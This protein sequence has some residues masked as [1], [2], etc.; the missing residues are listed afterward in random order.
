[1]FQS[2]SPAGEQLLL[3]T[4]QDKTANDYSPD[5]R[6]IL[7][8]SNDQKTG[9]DLWVLPLEGKREPYVFLRTSS[10]ERRAAFS[11]DGRWVT[12]LSNESGPYA[13]YVRP[14]FEPNSSSPTR[15]SAGA[16]SSYWQISTQG[17][18]QPR[19]SPDGKEVY[20]ISPEGKLMAVPIKVT[21]GTLEAGA[22]VALFAPKI[23]GVDSVDAGLQYDVAQDGRFLLNTVSDDASPITVIVNW[24]PRPP[25]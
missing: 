21:G 3:A 8:Q 17:G 24:A 6:F 12:Y 7:F 4:D 15:T 10:N 18:I 14:F 5:G 25:N 20:Y 16:S 11:P 13:V 19:W 1:M 22:P 23:F 9:I 2:T